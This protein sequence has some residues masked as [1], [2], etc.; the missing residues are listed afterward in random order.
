MTQRAMTQDEI[1]EMMK[2]VVEKMKEM[3]PEELEKMLEEQKMSFVRAEL[4]F[5]LDADEAA[6]RRAIA[7]NDLA[8]LLQLDSEN[9]ARIQKATPDAQQS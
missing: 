9:A 2:R 1:N 6:Y 5:G 8:T 7:E 3:S 4:G